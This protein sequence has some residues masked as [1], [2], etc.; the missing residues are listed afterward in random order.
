[1]PHK[2]AWPYFAAA[3]LLSSACATAPAPAPAPA[4]AKIAN[5]TRKIK[6]LCSE[7]ARAARF[8]A[9]GV[10]SDERPIDVA[11]TDKYIWVLFEPAR[12]MRIVRQGDKVDIEM[13]V[14]HGDEHWSS[15][16]V[17][18]ADG[19]VWVASDRKLALLHLSPTWSRETI[20]L[21][22]VEGEGGFGR[23]LVAEDALYVMPTSAERQVWRVDRKGKV[24]DTHFPAKM[25]PAE[26]AGSEVQELDQFAGVGLLRDAEGHVVVRNLSTGKVLQADG[27]GGWSE[28]PDI[29]WFD[30][31][32]GA[33]STVKGI[34]VGGKDERWFLARGAG[35]LFFW[36]GRPVF[37][38]PTAVG[39]NGGRGVGAQIFY[40]PDP[41]G[42]SA[43]LSE[44]YEV[45]SEDFIW[46]IT[47]NA[48][49]YAA[50][51]SKTVLFG[52]FAD[53]PDLP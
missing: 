7:K 39:G 24:L 23:L 11:V 19:S 3:L 34:N 45:C 17:D 32:Q 53:A 21:K 27:K 36:K 9:L 52:D 13:T 4:P 26:L 10:P 33:F 16:D 49:S 47:S 31:A 1:M 2:S 8:A 28:R 20:P 14:G 6:L 43:G 48:T 25:K 46:G 51:T 5:E 30:H 29:H 12:L 42:G 18:P 35:Q 38:G 44:F 15:F 41:T 22:K 50:I 37:A 40:V